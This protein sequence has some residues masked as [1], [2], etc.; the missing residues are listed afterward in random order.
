MAKGKGTVSTKPMRALADTR[1]KDVS[2]AFLSS[3]SELRTGVDFERL[4]QAIRDNDMDAVFAACDIEEAAF[5]P[6]V[7][8]L[9]T[10]YNDAGEMTAS[11]MPLIPV[12]K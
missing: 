1:Q 2:G 6:V 9:K 8:Q 3:V 4:V 11:L 10:V 12:K 5:S 7:R